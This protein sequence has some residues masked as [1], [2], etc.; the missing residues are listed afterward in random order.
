MK[1]TELL[2]D[3]LRRDALDLGLGVMRE[4]DGQIDPTSVEDGRDPVLQVLPNVLSLFHGQCAACRRTWCGC[5]TR[6]APQPTG[7]VGVSGRR[8]VRVP[9]ETQC[10][11]SRRLVLGPV[12]A[13][14]LSDGFGSLGN[15]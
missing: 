6:G 4:R 13:Q 3:G 11:A 5:R 10:C 9:S 12:A 2:E 8:N 7:P 1:E 14:H 15:I